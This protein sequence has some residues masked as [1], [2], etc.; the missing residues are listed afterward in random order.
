MSTNLK[1]RAWI[2]VQAHALRENYTRI[3]ETVGPDIRILPMVKANAYG[4]GVAEVVECLG[5]LDPWGFGV[6]TVQEGVS[7]REIGVQRPVVVCSPVPTSEIPRAVAANLELAISSLAALHR[8]EAAARAVSCLVGVHVEVDTGL[9]RSGFDWRAAEC[10][11]PTISEKRA[12]TRWAGC[13]THLHSA[14][15]DAASIDRQWER[16]SEVLAQA[17][18]APDGLM[19]HVLNSAGIFRAPRLA[20]ALVR[21]GIF[22]YGGEIGAE[23]P[24]PAS[25]V[26]VHARVVHIREVS[27]GTTL[28]YGVTYQ[29]GG[30]ERWATLSIG[31]ADGL[32][33]SLGERGSA[34]IGGKR[35]PIL[36]RISMDV[37]VV[38]ITDVPEVIEGAVAT[39]IGRDGDEVIT[40]ED[41]AAMAGTI[42]YEI[43]VGLTPRLPRVWCP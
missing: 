28:G 42:N 18:D 9:G 11:L 43:L 19:V 21:P 34:L 36:G 32:P 35:V 23:L 4:F 25:V 26:S 14:D 20:N 37:T 16:L 30:P 6:A 7:L 17:S 33:R 38:D 1:A 13:Y 29:A 39:L 27:A 15:V 3:A 40:V 31:Y 10:W 2:E 5:S 41:V 24:T 12:H 22:L 8:T